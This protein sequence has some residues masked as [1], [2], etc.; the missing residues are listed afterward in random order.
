LKLNNVIQRFSFILDI[1]IVLVTVAVIFAAADMI[2]HKE[3]ICCIQA[4]PKELPGVTS[5]M[6]Y[7]NFEN[8]ITVVTWSEFLTTDPDVRVLFP[9]L[10]HFL[11][12]S[13]SGTGSTQ[14]RE[15]NGG[16]I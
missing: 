14:P 2:L 12:S 13:V 7:V 1:A 6:L 5:D 11:R 10:P 3:E 15:C 16:A 4:C 9:E 8:K